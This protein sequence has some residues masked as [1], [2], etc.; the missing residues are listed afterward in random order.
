MHKAENRITF[1]VLQDWRYL[2]SACLPRLETGSGKVLVGA[3]G[4]FQNNSNNLYP[5]TRRMVEATTERICQCLMFTITLSALEEWH[6][7][8]ILIIFNP[9]ACYLL[10]T[11]NSLPPCSRD[12]HAD[13]GLSLR[14]RT[15]KFGDE[16]QL[17]TINNAL[18]LDAL[19]RF[20]HN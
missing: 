16:V 18:I 14:R 4:L 7:R 12:M 5:Q 9:S 3:D 20:S 15:G 6:I 17:S 10:L 19:P 13:R 2:L 11:S 1:T 8:A